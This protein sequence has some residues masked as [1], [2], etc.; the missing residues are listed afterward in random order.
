VNFLLIIGWNKQMNI[1]INGNNAQLNVVFIILNQSPAYKLQLYPDHPLKH[2]HDIVAL[3]PFG[4]S[5]HIPS[6]TPSNLVF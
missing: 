1:K 2:R 4:V 3:Y 5:I 6:K